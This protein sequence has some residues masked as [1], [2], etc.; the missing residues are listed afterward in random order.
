[1]KRTIIC[2]LVFVSLVIPILS[3]PTVS[4]ADPILKPR[5]YHGPIPKRYFTISIGVMGGA[6]NEEMWNFLAREVDEVLR[7]EATTDDFGAA[8]SIECSYTTKLHPQFAVRGK[9]ALTILRSESR[10]LLI[11]DVEPDTTGVLPL[12]EFERDFNI[13]LFSLDATGLFYFQDASVKSFQSYIGGGFSLYIPRAK[14]KEELTDLDTGEAFAQGI[15][16]QSEW[17]VNPGIH[18]ILG[19]LYHLTPTFAVNAEARTQIAQSKFT[20]DYPTRDGV[21]ALSFDVDYVGFSLTVG[22]AKFF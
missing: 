14:L 10:G 18:A 4:Y 1:M 15:K 5:K 2:S 16:E 21:Q 13:L 12:V 3:P 11:P 7:D 20:L 8:P 9:G 17:S 22:V 19:F 6:D